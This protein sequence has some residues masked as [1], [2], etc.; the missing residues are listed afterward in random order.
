MHTAPSTDLGF[1]FAMTPYGTSRSV[2]A[3]IV[4]WDTSAVTSMSYTFFGNY[5][6]SNPFNMNRM[7]NGL[8]LPKTKVCGHGVFGNILEDIKPVGENNYVY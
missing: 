7:V 5:V 3:D 1:Y 8:A 6:H 4:D 2:P